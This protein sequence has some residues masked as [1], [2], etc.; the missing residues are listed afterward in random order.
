M[1]K[2]IQ[3]LILGC[4][5]F[6]FSSIS[7]VYALIMQDNAAKFFLARADVYILLWTSMLGI[8]SLLL[9]IR[10][11]RKRPQEK[12]EKI[13][14]K[15]VVVSVFL[16]GA[17]IALLN[18]LGF[19]ISSLL[20]V[21]SLLFFYTFEA[22]Y[23]ELDR[24]GIMRELLICLIITAITVGAAYYLFGNILGLRLPQPFWL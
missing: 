6:L 24:K 11:V 16:I 14:T 21:F 10:S 15:R 22:K 5:L 8:L 18:I 7:F 1:K 13:L 17:F 23:S 3:D 4:V 20:L 12:A 19:T 9:I 2:W